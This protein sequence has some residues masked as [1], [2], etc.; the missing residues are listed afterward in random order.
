MEM[1]TTESDDGVLVKM[2]GQ[3]DAGTVDPAKQKL[4][5]L[6]KDGHNH[7][8]LDL[9]DVTFIDSTGLGMLVGLLKKVRVGEGDVLLS[10]LRAPVRKIFE[11]THL[12][13]VFKI[14]A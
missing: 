13:R 7:F 5:Q 1:T 11:L 3:L 12:D 2:T 10:G 14:A 6:L 8:S 9:S 4:E